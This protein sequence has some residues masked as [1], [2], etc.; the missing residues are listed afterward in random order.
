MFPY[1]PGIR[2]TEKGV[3]IIH[4]SSSVQ[5]FFCLPQS[6]EGKKE[7]ARRMAEVLAEAVIR[8]VKS[9]PCSVN[10]QRKLL[11]AVIQSAK[12]KTG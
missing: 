2:W 10:D 4:S 1:P 12:K 8:T 11:D 6:D 7:L 9:L 5:L 3:S